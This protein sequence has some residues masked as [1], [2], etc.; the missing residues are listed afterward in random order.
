M[1]ERLKHGMV[2]RKK[3]LE[4]GIKSL[5]KQIEIHKEKKEKAAEEGKLELEKY[6]AGEIEEFKRVREKKKGHLNR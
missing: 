2:K 1:K 3:R 4:R 5:N 6:Y